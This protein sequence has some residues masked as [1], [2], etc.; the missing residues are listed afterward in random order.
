[1]TRRI[2]GL[3]REHDRGDNW[4]RSLAPYISVRFGPSTSDPSIDF[5]IDTGA[6]W[7]TLSPRDAL[8]LLGRSYLDIDFDR[9]AGRIDLIGIGDGTGSAIVSPMELWFLDTDGDDHRI[10]MMVAIC[11]PS[12]A[13]PG[14]H[15]NWMMPSLLGRDILK[16]FDL[17]LSYNPPTVTLTEAAPA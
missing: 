9:S 11:K 6:D 8:S 2:T 3:L 12:P 15:G 17:A 14:R 16:W 7:T 5:L 13:T 10:T 4:K 1:M